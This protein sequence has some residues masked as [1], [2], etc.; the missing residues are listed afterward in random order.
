MNLIDTV[1]WSKDDVEK[2]KQ[3]LRLYGRA[4]GRVYKE[5]GGFKTATQCKQFYDDY[6]TDTELDLNTALAE[7]SARKVSDSN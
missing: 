7:H 5:V 4:W 2:L 6:C 3:G 1:E